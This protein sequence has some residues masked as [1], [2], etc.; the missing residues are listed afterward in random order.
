MKLYALAFAAL[1]AA[2]PVNAAPAPDYTLLKSVPLGTPDRWDYV[3]YDDQTQRVFVAHGDRLAVVDARTGNLVGQVEG[4]AGGTHGTAISTATHQGFTD[5]G[6]NG[7]AVAFDLSTLKVTRQIPADVDAD[8]IASDRATGHL[9]IIEGDPAAMTV[10]DPRTDAPVATIKA[11]EKLEYGAGD[12]HGSIFV[13]GVANG[14]LVKVDARTNRVVAHWPTPGCTAPH[15]LAVDARAHRVFMGCANS[16]MAVVDGNSGRV[17]AML[18]IGR[19][20]DA[21]A[22]DSVRKRVFS[23]NGR[24]GTI[25]VY[26]E[27]SPD[28]YVALAPVQTVVSA[29]TM[30]VDPVTGR[31]FVAAADTVPSPTPGGRPQVKPGTVRL[32]IFTPRA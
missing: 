14:D 17:V 20:N 4:I 31:L 28:R 30:S 5:D 3:V 8:A 19:G 32:L 10:I 6:R 27:Q 23:S 9:F 25:T 7:K 18:P 1:V 26:Q 16:V 12:G 2:A 24:D 13:A 11:G 22:F 15:G 21:V 29:R